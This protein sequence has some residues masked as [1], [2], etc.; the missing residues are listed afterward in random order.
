MKSLYKHTSA[1]LSVAAITL[2]TGC[3]DRVAIAQQ[4]MQHI[5]EEPAAPIQQIPEPKIIED[6]VY[7][8][9][10]VRSPFLP[11]SL[12]NLKGKI[13]ETEGVHPDFTRVKEPL[14]DYD[15]SELTYRGMVISPEGKQY[16]LIQRPDG[17]ITSVQVGNYM[18]KNDG[19]IVEIT[20]TQINLIEIVEDNRNGYVEKPQSLVSPIS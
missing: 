20:P 17:S 8:A 19:R 4:A 5:R 1:I 9:N 15:L 14:E 13:V 6:F 18:G 16:G 2:L 12:V 10:G 3:S 11:P 7:N